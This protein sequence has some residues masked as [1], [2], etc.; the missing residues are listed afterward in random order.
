MTLLLC[1]LAALNV[2]GLAAGGS[3]VY[4]HV[5]GGDL[6][7]PCGGPSHFAIA[8]RADLDRVSAGF[9]AKCGDRL[10]AEWRERIEKSK[11]DFSKEALVVLYEV[12]GTGGKAQLNVVGP[13]DGVLHAG[14]TWETP[15]GP[16]LPIATAALFVIAVDKTRVKRIEIGGVGQVPGAP[17]SIDLSR[18]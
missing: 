13:S 10:A 17:L 9:A 16:A 2:G 6:G 3:P 11:V 5:S 1:L 12:I 15:K 18:P 8:S 7:P 14:I 4:R